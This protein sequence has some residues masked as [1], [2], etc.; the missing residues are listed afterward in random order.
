MRNLLWVMPPLAT[1]PIQALGKAT[2]FGEGSGLR[3]KLP[4]E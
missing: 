3:R 1:H 2:L 4:V